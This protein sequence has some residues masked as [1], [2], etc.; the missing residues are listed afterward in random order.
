MSKKLPRNVENAAALLGQRGGLANTEKQQL[1]RKLNA[2]RAGRPRRVC[3]HCGEP[4]IGGHVDRSL[5]S[6]CGAHGW[7]WQSRA[8]QF[9][10]HSAP[11][12]KKR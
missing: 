7:R 11:K 10:Q 9:A 2:K 8:E 3:L 5:D 12:G 6:S 4:V 1:T